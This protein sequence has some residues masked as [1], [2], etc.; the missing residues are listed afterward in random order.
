M[1]RI[2]LLFPGQGSQFVGMGKALCDE[3]PVA[4][5]TFKE[6]NEVLGYDITQIC[7]QGNHSLLN[8]IENS[9]VAMLIYGVAAYR[10]Y[11]QEIG[12]KP[13]LAAGHSLGEYTALVCSGVISYADTLRVVR[14]RSE[15]AME[16]ASM[17]R[18]S[19]SLINNLDHMLVARLC[20]RLSSDQ[21]F[22]SIAAINA[23]NQVLIAGDEQAVMSVE[24]AGIERGG[25]ITPFLMS[26]PFHC[27][28]MKTAA[29][30]LAVELQNLIY[31][32]FAFPVISNV[33][34]RPY[35]HP[36]EICDN[37]IQQMT[38]PVQWQ[39]TYSYMQEQGITTAIEMGPQA[40]ITNLTK[41]NAPLIKGYSFGKNEE[42]DLVIEARK[43]SALK[44]ETQNATVSMASYRDF[45]YSC[46][47]EA[48]A[49]RNR[50]WNEEEYQ[51]GV[52]KPYQMINEIAEEIDRSNA[53]P[54]VEQ[55]RQ[56]LS[57]LKTILTTKQLPLDQLQ[58]RLYKII[59]ETRTSDIFLQ[60]M[61]EIS[62]DYYKNVDII[63]GI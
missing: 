38:H 4:C 7:F 16:V 50:N 20:E 34:A 40:I 63:R 32:D 60:N 43:L 22:A 28:R 54:S 2:A 52:V 55:I 30:K 47:V 9:L 5:A 44:Y 6:A 29:D 39:Q 12:I 56:A 25:E 33:T 10:V 42:R 46:L 3:F 37:L 1:E 21:Q 49:T 17:G 45:I 18:Y 62:V 19:M 36:E 24:D 23:A 59:E 35:Q 27:M 41:Q 14:K 51:E 53:A 48:V 15:L 61:T 57:H 13:D 11:Q 26:P 8:K 58:Q 31:Y